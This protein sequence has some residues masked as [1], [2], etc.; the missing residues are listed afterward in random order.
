MRTTTW[1]AFCLLLT[2]P[3]GVHAEPRV[4]LVIGN[5]AYADAPLANPVNDAH[6]IAAS[7]KQAGFRVTE[8][9]NLDLDHLRKAIQ[10]F[11]DQL[12]AAGQKRAGLVYYSGHG[13]QAGG[14][15][16]L[17]PIGASI[18]READLELQALDASSLMR[19]MEDAGAGV[20]IVVLD[21]CRNNPFQSRTRSLSK[22]LAQMKAG[23]GAFFLAYATAP[24]T[25]AQD[26]KGANSPY[27]KALAAA[28]VL[29]DLP[30]EEAFKRVRVQVLRETGN[31]Q[32]PWELSSLLTSFYFKAVIAPSAH[33]AAPAV[34]PSA[35][36]TPPVPVGPT[37]SRHGVG[38][39]YRDCADCPEM[40]RIPAGSF[41]MGSPATEQER[42][43][44][45]SPRHSVRVPAFSIGKY[46]VT[47][48]EWD[49]CMAARGCSK[50]PSDEGWGR[51][52][53][54]VINVSWSDA[55]QYVVWLST[56]TGKRYRLPSEAEWEYAA[57]AGTTTAYHWGDKIGHGNANCD[58]CGSQWDAKQTAPVGRFGP[59]AFG[60]Y[61]MLG[62]VWQWV[63]DCD[64][65]DYRHAPAD[66]S[67]WESRDC[68]TRAFRGGSWFDYPHRSRAAARA[69]YN[70]FVQP[71]DL[72]G[73]VVGFRVARDSD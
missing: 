51:G 10:A 25:E 17:I 14:H 60:L 36:L 55:R 54:P 12:T 47:F 8:Y 70:I 23:E 69:A 13:V 1:V 59:N 6:L 61:D 30:I 53:R 3:F 68:A 27:A 56:K 39:S 63:Q 32:Q 57:R 62:N 71:N 40:A 50:R 65:G 16:Y 4:A 48:E 42:E 5:A 29:P 43:D 38:E 24:D 2:A 73:S 26:G 19:Q 22:G 11:G 9:A 15:N 52:Q 72:G 64:H 67:A 28:M 41:L 49:A 58:G 35:S 34:P 18:H 44:T 7:L 37:V 31:Q 33:G 21:A 46:T 66:G 45:E 20:N